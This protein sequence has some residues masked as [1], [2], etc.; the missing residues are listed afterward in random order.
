VA[1]RICQLSDVSVLQ[2]H[3][4]AIEKKIVQRAGPAQRGMLLAYWLATTHCGRDR[5]VCALPRWNV[6]VRIVASPQES[7]VDGVSLD[8]FTVGTVRD[9]STSLGSWLV[10]QGYAQLEMR[11]DVVDQFAAADQSLA[12]LNLTPDRRRND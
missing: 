10:A 12:F 2:V 3:R 7:E 4:I 1:I 9:V 11:S 6:K 5:C 8:S